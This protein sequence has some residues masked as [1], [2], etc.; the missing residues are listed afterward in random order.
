MGNSNSTLSSSKKPN[1]G[2]LDIPFGSD[3]KKSLFQRSKPSFQFRKRSKS[4]L[5]FTDSAS[6]N[7]NTS[8]N[9]SHSV[10]KSNQVVP[11]HHYTI[12]TSDGHSDN[13]LQSGGS[14]SISNQKSKISSQL[15]KQFSSNVIGHH[16]DNSTTNSSTSSTIGGA[17]PEW[18]YHSRKCDDGR[19][20]HTVDTAPYMLPNDLTESDRLDAQH[21]LVRFILKGNYNVKIDPDAPVKILDVATGTGVW[22]LEMAHEFPKAEIH[23][24]DISPIFPTEIKPSNCHFQLCNI[25]DGLPFPDNYFD[26]IYQRLLVYALTP[27]QRKQVNAE[28][29]RVLKP[30]GHLQLVESDGI[31]YNAGPEMEKI[32]QLSLETSLRHGVD[33]HEVQNMK[34]GLKQGGYTNVNSFNIAL[35]VGDWGGK[36]G[37][38]SRENMHGLATIWLKGEVGKM[39]QEACDATLAIADK[40]C[41]ENQSYYKVWL[42][43]GQKPS[44]AATQLKEAKK[45]AAALVAAHAAHA[46]AAATAA[47]QGPQ[48]SSSL[49]ISPSSQSVTGV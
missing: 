43:V 21:Y 16:G 17:L 2:S 42:V 41:E 9:T 34:A 14:N 15:K 30:E 33:P 39:N 45:A 6:S 44:V 22:A 11:N 46:A 24:V 4:S 48:P 32:N 12:D 13:S 49:P 19:T 18:A 5:S 37:A 26:F 23:G 36:V 27:A 25:L 28:L 1:P 31:V 35:P 47:S 3:T 10:K 29:L 7:S 40:E 20:R 38:L 8:G